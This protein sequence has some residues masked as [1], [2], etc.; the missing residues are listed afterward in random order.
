[1][2][3]QSVPGS[4]HH[5][6]LFDIAAPRIAKWTFSEADTLEEIR[7]AHEPVYDGSAVLV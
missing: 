5:E 3:Q 2:F 7:R 6:H 4:R 1:M